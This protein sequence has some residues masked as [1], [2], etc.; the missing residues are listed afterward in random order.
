MPPLTKEELLD[1]SRFDANAILRGVQL[2]FVGGMWAIESDKKYLNQEGQTANRPIAQ[3]A[4]Q[5]PNLW[6]TQHY[7][8]AAIAVACGI[9][10]RILIEIPVCFLLHDRINAYTN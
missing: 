10:I 5:N 6:T 7:R 1:F 2:T 8:Q 9:A 3:R 4:L